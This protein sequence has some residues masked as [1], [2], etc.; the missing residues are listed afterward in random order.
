MESR[1]KVLW[2][3]D[4]ALGDLAYLTA[5]LYMDGGYEL[6]VAE[7]VSEALSFLELGEFDA[8][9]VD[10]R[11]FPGHRSEWREAFTA[12]GA[13]KIEAK[14]GLQLLY[15]I[16]EPRAGAPVTVQEEMRNKI[17][18]W[19]GS[20][21]IGVLTVETWEELEND[22]KALNISESVHRRKTTDVPDTVLLDLVEAVLAQE[23]Q[24]N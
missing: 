7:T 8:V 11:L 13:N 2:I 14:L 21:R 19:L 12:L 17:R 3:E 5:P 10:I 15:A 20:N 1:H 24:S 23:H 16:L 18:E 9:I 6:V 4:S 22:F